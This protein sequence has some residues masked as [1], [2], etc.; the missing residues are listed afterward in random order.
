MKDSIVAIVTIVLLLQY[1]MI[2]NNG[3]IATVEQ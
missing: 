3:T 2:N 1:K